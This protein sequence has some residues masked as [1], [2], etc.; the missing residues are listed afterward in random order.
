MG[1]LG[2][3]VDMAVLI[4]I[5]EIGSPMEIMCLWKISNGVFPCRGRIKN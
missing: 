5:T 2:E 3:L 4:M 1:G